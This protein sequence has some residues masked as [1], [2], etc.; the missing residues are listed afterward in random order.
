MDGDEIKTR[1]FDTLVEL[2]AA[3]KDNGAASFVPL[4]HY[5]LSNQ[6]P[7]LLMGHEPV[8]HLVVTGGQALLDTVNGFAQLVAQFPEEALFIVWL[9][10]YWGPIETS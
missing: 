3:S 10:S 2:V 7:A 1:N 8:I 5:L 4:S 9:N 6:V